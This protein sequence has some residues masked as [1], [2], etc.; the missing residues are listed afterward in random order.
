MNRSLFFTASIFLFSLLW[1][2][3]TAQAVEPALADK[4]R[5]QT[6]SEFQECRND[7]PQFEKWLYRRIKKIDK[8]TIR[9][10][11]LVIGG[12]VLLLIGNLGGFYLMMRGRNPGMVET[13]LVKTE[14]LYVSDSMLM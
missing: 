4:D 14:R 7:I 9:L 13:S 8:R 2:P 5:Q 6:I 11:N 12:F 3:E 10:T 1:T